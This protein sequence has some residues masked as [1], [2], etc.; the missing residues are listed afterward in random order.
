VSRRG[1]GAI[2]AGYSVTVTISFE[3]E[4]IPTEQQQGLIKFADELNKH[5]HGGPIRGR[6]VQAEPH[7]TGITATM[8]RALQMYMKDEE[9]ERWRAAQADRMV[10]TGGK[11]FIADDGVVTAILCPMPGMTQEFLDLAAHELIEMAE[12][13]REQSD[14]WVSPTDP[15]EADGITLF[16][17]YRNERVRQ[18]IRE[19]L[20]WPEGQLDASSGLVSMAVEISDRMPATR[21]DPPPPEFWGAW[22]HLGQVWAMVSGRGAAGSASAQRDLADWRQHKFA[23]A[24]GWSPIAEA[25]NTLYQEPDLER[26]QLASQAAAGVRRPLIAYGRQAWRHGP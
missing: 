21:L 9:Y 3:G 6:I 11:T 7:P 26:D 2:A 13:I 24:A 4:P 25:M 15:D 12:L 20:S 10:V 14:G 19:R 5:P 23:S 1:V 18:E 22:L 16:D 17:E 8:Q